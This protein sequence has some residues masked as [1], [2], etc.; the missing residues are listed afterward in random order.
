MNE[1]LV[2]DNQIGH[3]RACIDLIATINSEDIEDIDITV[4]QGGEYA[5]TV[6][7]K[8]RIQ[9]AKVFNLFTTRLF[10]GTLEAN[11]ANSYQLLSDREQIEVT[12][13]LQELKNTIN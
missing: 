13:K 7:I 5:Q 12:N 10:T 6:K 9:E 4:H 2:S 1:M 11:F 8:L 3:D